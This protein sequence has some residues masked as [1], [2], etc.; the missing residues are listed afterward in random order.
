MLWMR[1]LDGGGRAGELEAASSPIS[2]GIHY[3]GERPEG[4]TN[5]ARPLRQI[6]FE[7]TMGASCLVK[8]YSISSSCENKDFR[9]GQS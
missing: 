9:S 7:S 3:N 4:H 2:E 5:A 6:E 1:R 8:I